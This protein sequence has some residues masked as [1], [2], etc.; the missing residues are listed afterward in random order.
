M[1]VP[2]RK[3]LLPFEGAGAASRWRLELPSAFRSFDYDTISDVVLS[4]KYTARDGGEV[5]RQAA[6]K[7]LREM[8]SDAD[9]QPVARIFSLRHE[10]PNAWH[11]FLAGSEAGPDRTLTAEI[12]KER[13]PFIFRDR[14]IALDGWEIYIKVADAHRAALTPATLKIALSEGEDASNDVLTLGRGTAC[15]K[16]HRRSAERWENGHSPRGAATARCT[17]SSRTTLSTTSF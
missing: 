12:G 16:Q 5:L 2:P 1:P 14:Q 7:A 13:F 4:L 6:G 17:P 11:R 3:N 10:F 8:L 15:C 9:Q